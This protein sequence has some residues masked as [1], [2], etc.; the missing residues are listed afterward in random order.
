MPL[1]LYP[2]KIYLFA[3]SFKDTSDSNNKKSTDW[4]WG[5]C[6]NIIHENLEFESFKLQYHLKK[7]EDLRLP[8]ED[9]TT[10]RF[11]SQN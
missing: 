8:L 11:S 3:Y 2:P 5:K 4:L 7:E 9:L 6:N 1:K 10:E